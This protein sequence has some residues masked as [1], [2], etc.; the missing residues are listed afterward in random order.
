MN[1]NNRI[2][3]YLI[4]I[5][6][7]VS[8]MATAVSVTINMSSNLAVMDG[9]GAFGGMHPYASA[10]Y[11]QRSLD[12]QVDTLGLSLLRIS[13]PAAM[14]YRNDNSDP[15]VFD[16]STICWG[17]PAEQQDWGDALRRTV[18]FLKAIKTRAD[19]RGE[20]FR[21]IATS[22]S[23]PPW[24][25]DNNSMAGGGS[26]RPEM[27]A[28]YAE[29]VVAFIKVVKKETGIDI[30]AISLQNEPELAMWYISGLMN[31]QQMRDL[32]IV[33]G[34]RLEKE[35]LPTKLFGPESLGPAS[36]GNWA[37]PILAEPRAAR[38]Y[39]AFACHG[40]EPNGITASKGS[41]DGWTVLGNL[42]KKAGKVAWMT[43][44]A[45]YGGATEWAKAFD[46]A[47]GM[48]ISMT[49][50]NLT[51]WTWWQFGD[52]Y[53]ATVEG[54]SLIGDLHDLSKPPYVS[55]RFY[56]HKHFARFVK[57]GSVRMTAVSDDP[58]VLVLAFRDDRRGRVTVQLL[59]QA[60]AAKDVTISGLTGLDMLDL[61]QSDGTLL[62]AKKEPVAHGAV[63]RLPV[64][65]LT[66]LAGQFKAEGAPTA[67]I[68]APAANVNVPMGQSV[69]ITAEVTPGLS[70]VTAV[71]FHAGTEVIGTRAQ[72]PYSI[73]WNGLSVPGTVRL[74]VRI[75]DQEGNSGYSDP[76]MLHFLAPRG[77]GNGLQGAY[78]TGD[79]F[80]VP[81]L[82]RIDTTV[83]YDW[84]NNA[85]S[86][87]TVSDGF[88]VRWAGYVQPYCPGSYSFKVTGDD[89]F[90]LFIDGVKILDAW[91]PQSL[92]SMSVTVRFDT[93]G[94]K[95]IRLEYF[96]AGGGAQI[97]LQWAPPGMAEEVIPKSQLY[98]PDT[99]DPSLGAVPSPRM[100]HRK[101]LVGKGHLYSINGRSMPV[102]ARST[103]LYLVKAENHSRVF[104]VNEGSR[105]R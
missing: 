80:D 29:W 60:S 20:Q 42:V 47:L 91:Q 41:I 77:S 61:Y 63:V 36:V 70:P 73:T 6:H 58:D 17:Y 97:H 89:G 34:D 31:G 15:D 82:S 23:A 90:R 43:E 79:N 96:E 81:A 55:N 59:N 93:F 76:L 101:L 51:G 28:E 45:G 11:N 57:P 99:P 86:G 40:Y 19:S 24:M 38:H 83:D 100:A 105:K 46:V 87:M 39:Y 14:E 72:A 69:V 49:Y 37:G 68:T 66:T 94:R 62:C 9:F 95:E 3:T 12:W 8:Q 30:F 102:A 13:I 33:V 88:S 50:G 78:F 4:A 74:Q 16:E 84:G 35:G 53:E 21:V 56:V 48:F 2:F 103:G 7:V 5:I 18:D 65:S 27:Y 64:Q 25:K 54:Y 32:S 104:I 98:T 26:I 22:W 71:E 92:T 44:T 85:P 67:R 1:R 52:E 10:L 75:V